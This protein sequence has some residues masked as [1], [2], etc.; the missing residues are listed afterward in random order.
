M[1]VVD[2]HRTADGLLEL[3]VDLTAG[4]WSI[5]FAGLPWHTHGDILAELEG[6]SAESA[7]RLYVAD[8][9]NS[10]KLIVVRRMNGSIEDAWVADGPTSDLG[11]YAPPNTT[12]ELRYWNGSTPSP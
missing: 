2:R 1:A 11:R 5:G 12:F 6:G 8:V 9:L 4:D 7:T 10:N 3:I